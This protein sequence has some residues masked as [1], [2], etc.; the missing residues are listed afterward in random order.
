MNR[1]IIRG[2]NQDVE[3]PV[4]LRETFKVLFVGE[5]FESQVWLPHDAEVTKAT[6]TE[7]IIEVRYRPKQEPVIEP[8][9][10]P[11]PL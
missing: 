8:E 5:R 10:D 2:L 1:R 3:T 9:T 7:I 6:D 4:G 11:V